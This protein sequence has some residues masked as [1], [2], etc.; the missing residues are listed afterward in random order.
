[1]IRSI[2]DP[3]LQPIQILDSHPLPIIYCPQS[4]EIVRLLVIVDAGS[5]YERRDQYGVA[6]FL[7]H[8][9]FRGTSRHDA[10]QISSLFSRL[11]D[12]NA[13][14][15]YEETLFWVGCLERDFEQAFELLLELVSM[16]TLSES[17][18]EKE[19]EIVAEEWITEH[20]NPRSFFNRKSAANLVAN[21]AW[22]DILGTESS[23]RTMTSDRCEEFYTQWYTRGRIAVVVCGD[24][25]LSRI[26]EAASRFIPPAFAKLAHYRE[27]PAEQPLTIHDYHF[28]Y[29]SAQSFFSL[30]APAF[31]ERERSVKRTTACHAFSIGLGVD[32]H[33]LLF[34]RLRTELGLCYSIGASFGT[35]R[36]VGIFDIECALDASKIETA[37]EEIRRIC[38]DVCEF[39]FTG[40]L[41]S[42][43]KRKMLYSHALKVKQESFGLDAAGMFFSVPRET[44][45]ELADA[46]RW[47]AEI[48]DLTNADIIE[49]ATQLVGDQDRLKLITMTPE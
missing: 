21:G 30:I 3:S 4:G 18:I 13:G 42:V 1:M 17:E 25:G 40:D 45:A 24:I 19:I 35:T 33:S 44:L 38:R 36:A 31:G 20:G 8:M 16:P 12:Y 26:G 10:K 11:G 43:V 27:S 32:S 23:I 15:T 39:G 34:D 37:T 48:E 28:H 2:A 9:T 6:H 22:H 41:L 49:V 46:D 29:K 14:T 7:E 47:R 5:S